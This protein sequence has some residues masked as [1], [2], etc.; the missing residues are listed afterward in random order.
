VRR[1]PIAV[2]AALAIGIVVGF[3]LGGVGPRREL[4]ETRDEVARLEEEL[5]ESGSGSGFRSAVPGLDRILR[6]PPETETQRERRRDDERSERRRRRRSG[7]A[8]PDER[9]DGD[10]EREDPLAAFGRA[11]AVQR[12][13][14]VQSRAA[15][16]QQADLDPE[17]LAEVDAAFLEMNEELAG[18]GEELLLLALDGERPAPREL[19]GITHDVTGILH[20]AQLRLEEIVGPERMGDVDP[21]ALEIWNHVDLEQLEPAARAAVDRMR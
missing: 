10:G 2:V 12:V 18:Y 13:R 21:E 16:E 6:A 17:A 3:A 20:R 8:G 1:L 5:A 14:N 15:L 7:D 19:L 9:R 4:V 11:A